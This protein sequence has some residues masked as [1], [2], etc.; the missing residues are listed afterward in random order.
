MTMQNE[1]ETYWNGE[2]EL[3][4]DSIQ[5]E[6]NGFEKQ[7]WLDLILEYAP[8]KERLDVLDIG[9]GPGFFTII[10]SQAGH[11]VLGIDCTEN[12]LKCARRNAEQAGVKPEFRK[13]DSQ[14]PE[15][16][17]DSFD[18]IV[19]RNLTWTLHAPQAAYGEWLKV[20]RPGGRLLVFDANWNRHFIDDDLRAK[21]DADLREYEA[22]GWGSPP[23]HVDWEESDRLSLLLPLTKE[24]RPAWDLQALKAEGYSDA[25]SVENLSERVLD[26]RQQVLSRS[27]P[28]FM[29]CG[30][31]G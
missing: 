17:S 25:F 7:A 4:S 27:T 8:P 6:L 24:W 9:C 5:K 12:M 18:L 10:L 13:M 20:L 31:K 23:R 3:Y 16:E 22:R 14:K 1:I 19:C 28:M 30:Q 2:A 15:L 26:E 11:N 21:R 29:V